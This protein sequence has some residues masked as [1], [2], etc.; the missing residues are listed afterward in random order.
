VRHPP[1]SE[2][3]VV[4]SAN[5]EWRAIGRQFPDV[6]TQVS[7]F[8]EWFVTTVG[9]DSRSVLLFHGGWGKIAAAA[10]TQYIIQHCSPK[11]IVNLGTCGGFEGQVEQ[12]AIILVD[13]T[14]VYDIHVQMGDNDEHIAHYSTDIDLDWLTEPF[15]HP[16]IRSLMVSGDR[17]LMIES[18][19]LLSRQ[20]G[21]IVGDWESS[22][23]A[24]VA[25]KNGVRTLI[26]RGVSDLV[27]QSSGE[28]YDGKIHV[29]EENTQAIMD[30]LVTQLPDWLERLVQR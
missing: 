12:G 25:S 8:G 24:W 18:I 26:L 16:V 7:P 27:G 14:V 9:H 3:V 5:I 21:A 13:R 15:P 28:A 2:V 10:S 17:D 19:P 23:I 6:I 30:R 20:F 22:S 4:V 11:H 29:F 1:E